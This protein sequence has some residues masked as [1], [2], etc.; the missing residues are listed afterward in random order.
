MSS[1]ARTT[2]AVVPMGE[3][4]APVEIGT[5]F[6]REGE[7]SGESGAAASLESG[8]STM[9]SSDLEAAVRQYK[10]MVAHVP[11]NAVLVL[12]GV[13][14]MIGGPVLAVMSVY[15]AFMNSGIGDD[16]AIAFTCFGGIGLGFLLVI[17]GTAG[18]KSH[19][20]A[21]NEAFQHMVSLSTTIKEEETAPAKNRWLASVV[22]LVFLAVFFAMLDMVLMLVWVVPLV[23]A[24]YSH[25][26]NKQKKRTA[27]K[28][29]EVLSAIEQEINRK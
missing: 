7:A 2:K 9:S 28:Q 3:S 26:S 8:A 13:V 24:E 18:G 12:L 14:F 6:Y 29:A 10:A 20:K 21:T 1:P 16:A 22:G 11:G 4:P 5:T 15:D 23:F 17:V 27:A 25:H 19:E